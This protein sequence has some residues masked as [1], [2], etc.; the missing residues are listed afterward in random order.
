MAKRVRSATLNQ[1][2][3]MEEPR[4]QPGVDYRMPAS[5]IASRML[6]M[7]TI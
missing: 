1:P 2:D 5:N 6:V 4:V 7:G 3:A